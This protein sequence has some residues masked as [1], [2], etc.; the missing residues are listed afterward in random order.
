MSATTL[1]REQAQASILAAADELFYPNGVGSVTMAHVRDQ[2]GASLRR[3]Y[4]LYPA[5]SDLIT[6][7]LTF[8]HEQWLSW[9]A[10]EIERA[11]ELGAE[12]VDAVFDTL[13]AWLTDTGF[14][15]CGFINTLLEMHQLTDDHRRIIEDHKHDMTQ[16]LAEYTADPAAM[17]VL[18]DGA[19]V[20][21]AIYQNLHPVN[22]ARR[23]AFALQNRGTQACSSETTSSKTTSPKTRRID[24]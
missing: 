4:S 13:E 14:R 20:Q 24:P 21:A 12:R 3:L 19:I 6:G 2:S 18:V 8:R 16:V 15:G 1:T 17:A 7:W 11:V 10:D 5:K 23:A 9:F 22:A